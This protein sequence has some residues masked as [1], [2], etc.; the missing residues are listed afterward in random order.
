MTFEKQ[1]RLMDVFLSQDVIDDKDRNNRPWITERVQVPGTDWQ[2]SLYELKVIIYIYE[3]KTGDD[4]P[5]TAEDIV[6]LY[7]VPNEEKQAALDHLAMWYVRKGGGD[8]K[9]EFFAFVSGSYRLYQETYGKPFVDKERIMMNAE[10]E[11]ELAQW[12]FEHIDYNLIEK[13]INDPDADYV[14]KLYVRYL[15]GLGLIDRNGKPVHRADG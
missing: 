4:L 13:T 3:L 12:G 11:Y 5:L 10:E 14:S 9:S 8:E 7:S 6:E 1:L 2:V 15:Y